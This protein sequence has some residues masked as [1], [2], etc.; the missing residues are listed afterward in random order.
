[1]EERSEAGEAVEIGEFVVPPCWCWWWCWKEEL[2]SRMMWAECGQ[3]DMLRRGQWQRKVTILRWHILGVVLLEFA[4]K[5]N[6]GLL[7]GC[8]LRSIQ[9]A[10]GISEEEFEGGLVSLGID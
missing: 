1:V 8:R 7:G 3:H 4:G 10:I 9:R 6:V 2:L 5:A